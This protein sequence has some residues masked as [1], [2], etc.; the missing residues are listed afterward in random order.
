MNLFA[1]LDQAA[2]A[3]G[4]SYLVIGGHAVNAHGYTRFT[5]DLD[6]LIGRGEMEK[7]LAVL[8]AEGYTIQYDGGNFRQLSAPAKDT[9]PVDVMLVN[10]ATLLKMK[11]DSV[12]AHFDG[13]PFPIPSLDHLLGLKL[14]ALKHG[15]SHRGFKDFMDVLSLIEANR[16][17]VR[18][19]KFRALCDKYGDEKIYARI[20]DFA[21]G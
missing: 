20:I 3:Q 1:W 12:T 14:H 10:E 9:P 19:D 11:A 2:R 15:P 4:L 21:K 13:I 6:L 8:Q 17:D 7:W 5:K 18:G 16:I